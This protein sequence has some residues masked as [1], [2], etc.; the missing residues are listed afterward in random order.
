[1]AQAAPDYDVVIIGA[2]VVGSSCAMGLSQAG[3]KV[4]LLE[5]FELLGHGR[6]SSHGGARRIGLL[7]LAPGIRVQRAWDAWLDLQTK[8]PQKRLFDLTGE[9]IITKLFPHGIFILPFFAIW[10][11]AKKAVGHCLPFNMELLISKK[12]VEKKISKMLQLWLEH[13]GLVR[14]RSCRAAHSCHFGI[15]AREGKRLWR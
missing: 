4:L 11:L 3:K 9:V 10:A 1:M 8:Y 5:Q 12:H 14:R 7:D 6:G 2:G 15:N 13:C